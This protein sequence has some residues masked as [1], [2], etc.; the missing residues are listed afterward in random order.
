M[1]QRHFEVVAMRQTQ[2]RLSKD[3]ETDSSHSWFYFPR[4]CGLDGEA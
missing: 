4:P 2:D 1:L 3:A